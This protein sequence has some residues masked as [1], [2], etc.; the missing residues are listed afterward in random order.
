LKGHKPAVNSVLTTNMQANGSAK[1]AADKLFC[2]L[3]AWLQ[4]F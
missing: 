4:E 2:L 3:I 1:S